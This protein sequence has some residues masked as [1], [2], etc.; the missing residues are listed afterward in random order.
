MHPPSQFA[1][2]PEII[3]ELDP[4]ELD[5]YG[6]DIRR[7][8]DIG[9]DVPWTEIEDYSLIPIWEFHNQTAMEGI[10]GR[11]ARSC[12]H[13]ERFEWWALEGHTSEY[14]T[15]IWD[16]KIQRQGPGRA[17]ALSGQLLGPLRPDGFWGRF[18]VLVGKGMEKHR[19]LGSDRPSA[20]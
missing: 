16:W 5:H 18:P 12:C 3:G 14:F 13:L 6:P 8:L 17:K 1:Y 20:Y 2:E 10:V 9:P 4:L 7:A 19:D 15:M 11:L